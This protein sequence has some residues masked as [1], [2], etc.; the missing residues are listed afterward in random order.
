MRP[1]MLL[2]ENSRLRSFRVLRLGRKRHALLQG[3]PDASV[4]R[5]IQATRRQGLMLGPS[6]SRYAWQEHVMRVRDVKGVPTRAKRR[7]SVQSNAWYRS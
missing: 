1:A 2:H 7:R 6:T 5:V 3:E 4:C